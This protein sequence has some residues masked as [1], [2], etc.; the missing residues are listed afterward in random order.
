MSNPLVRPFAYR[1][2]TPRRPGARLW[3]IHVERPF[4]S[5]ELA[6]AEALVLATVRDA[7]EAEGK[8]AA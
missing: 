6:E 3:L 8:R 5:D 7:I 2:A 4:A 1:N